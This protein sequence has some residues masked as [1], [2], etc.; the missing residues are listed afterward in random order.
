MQCTQVAAG[1]VDVVFEAASQDDAVVVA[2]GRSGNSLGVYLEAPAM[3]LT[4]AELASRIVKLNTLAHLRSQVALRNELE[5]HRA[6]VSRALATEEQVR[7]FES[8]IDF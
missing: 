2:V 7:A 3:R 1:V 5:R 8:F 4:D 6:S